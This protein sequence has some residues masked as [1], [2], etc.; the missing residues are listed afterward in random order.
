MNHRWQVIPVFFAWVL[1]TKGQTIGQI[2]GTWEPVNAWETKAKCEAGKDQHMKQE[3][4]VLQV[5]RAKNIHICTKEEE[6]ETIL[7]ACSLGSGSVMV[8][9]TFKNE[10]SIQSHLCLPD[11]IDP[12]EKKE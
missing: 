3:R 10:T 7:M 4:R 1:W 11:T 8:F 2:P 12:R 6:D 9:E 5:V